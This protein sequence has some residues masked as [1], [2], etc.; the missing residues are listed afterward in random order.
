MRF[1][2]ISSTILWKSRFFPFLSHV[3]IKYSWFFNNFE[4]FTKKELFSTFLREFSSKSSI[5]RQ[6]RSRRDI[7]T[8]HTH[9]L[10]RVTSNSTTMSNVFLSN[11]FFARIL[12]ISPKIVSV[13]LLTHITHWHRIS[14]AHI[15][16]QI[17]DDISRWSVLT[18]FRKFPPP[19]NPSHPPL[20]HSP[21]QCIPPTHTHSH[22]LK[23]RIL[24]NFDFSTPSDTHTVITRSDY[25]QKF[26]FLPFANIA[27]FLKFSF[28]LEIYSNS[29]KFPFPTLQ[30][31]T[32][33]CVMCFFCGNS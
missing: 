13:T 7:V 20:T 29:Q 16:T 25:P 10:A 27:F 32:C 28:F 22:P 21:N 15:K 3:E 23:R 19:N 6:S 1:F 4:I 2:V 8:A 11:R 9:D 12:K 33:N 14:N 18:N 31:S 26:L 30:R 24:K 17:I 5:L